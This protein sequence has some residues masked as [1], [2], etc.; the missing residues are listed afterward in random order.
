MSESLDTGK[1]FR[2]API[3]PGY[4]E[5]QVHKVSLTVRDREGGGGGERENF[6]AKPPVRFSSFNK[7]VTHRAATDYNNVWIDES[8]RE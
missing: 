8:M 4:R 3:F 6:K 7:P 2:S 5:E 1:V